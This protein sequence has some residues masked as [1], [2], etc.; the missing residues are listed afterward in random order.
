[1]NEESYSNL[2]DCHCGVRFVFERE[3]CPFSEKFLQ[4]IWNERRLSLELHTEDGQELKILSPGTWN[5]SAGPDFTSAALLLDGHLV[6]GDVEI[7]RLSSDWNRHG[8]SDDNLYDGVVLH[9]VWQDDAPPI[10]EGVRT[11]VLSR[12][13]HPEWRRLLWDLEDAC[14]PYAR[15]V[16]LGDCALR[17]AMSSDERVMELLESAG[18]SRFT[19]KSSAMMRHAADCGQEQALYEA[20]FESLGYKNNRSQFLQIARGVP[21]STLLSLKSDKERIAL[22]FGYSGLLPDTT[23]DTVLQELQATVS[24]LWDC[25]WGLGFPSET[26]IQWNNAGT[27]PYNSPFRRLAAGIEMLQATSFHPAEWLLQQASLATSSK[28]LLKRFDALASADSPW[29]PYRDFC[30]KIMPPANLI[31]RPRLLDMLANVF[32]PFLHGLQ[33]AMDSTKESSPARE[34][35]MRLPLSQDNRMFKEAVQRFL[36]PPSRT[37][38]LIKTACHQQGMLDIY[39][40]FCIALDN[41]CQFC[42]FASNG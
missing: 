37:A 22:L 8:H 41:N 13:L 33:G 23:R 40:N 18:L 30:H 27:R 11:L 26:R 1:M 7:H 29:R 21:L 4:V 10:R 39:K 17:W 25:W 16:P 15:Q 35:F 28:D 3:A 5:V 24:E 12:H 2:Q 6:T 31:G 14:Y 38:D 36:M 19:S 32:L 42:P 9:V 20:I 34:L